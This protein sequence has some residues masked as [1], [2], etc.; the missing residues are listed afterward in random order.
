ML[1]GQSTHKTDQ[2]NRLSIPAR[3]RNAADFTRQ[4]YIRYHEMGFLE[5]GQ[6]SDFE[7]LSD[8]FMAYAAP[9][10]DAFKSPD[11]NGRVVIPEHLMRMIKDADDDSLVIFGRGK[12]FGICS[13]KKWPDIENQFK[14]KMQELSR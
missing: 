13:P 5:V 12:T 3:I 9:F 8:T 14:Q 10:Y 4:H 1:L 6:L 2:K 11:P 7:D